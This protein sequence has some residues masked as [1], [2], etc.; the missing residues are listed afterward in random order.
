[1]PTPKSAAL[2]LETNTRVNKAE[3]C[4]IL[5]KSARSLIEY[6]NGGRL[7]VEYRNG[8]HGAEASYLRADVVRLRAELDEP[9][10]REAP[11]NALARR[12]AHVADRASSL[13]LVASREVAPEDPEAM[14][15]QYLAEKRARWPWVTLDEAALGSGLPKGYLLRRAKE[16]A[17]FAINVGTEGRAS[18]RVNLEWLAKTC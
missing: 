14:R 12:A 8:K 10:Y 4:E 2:P 3:A 7:A 5:G 11:A 15:Q 6:V 17:E 18:W 13:A 9:M 16:G 1:M